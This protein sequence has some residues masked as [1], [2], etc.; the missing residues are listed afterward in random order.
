[1]VCG[2]QGSLLIQTHGKTLH[3]SCMSLGTFHGM[4]LPHTDVANIAGSNVPEMACLDLE[5]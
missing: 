3:C 5:S 2:E 4:P 1:M